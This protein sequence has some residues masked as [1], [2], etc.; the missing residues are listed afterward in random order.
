MRITQRAVAQTSLLGL[1]QNLER[2][3]K[4]QQQLTSGRQL[5]APSDSPTGTNKAMQVRQ[6]TAAVEQQARNISDG[7]GWLDAADTALTTILAQVRKVRDLTV[8]GLNTGSMQGNSALAISTEVTSLRE[9]L[10]GLAN[11]TIDGRPVFGGA[12][13]GSQAYD[14][15]GAFVGVGGLATIGGVVTDMTVPQLRRV[16]DTEVIR[17]DLTGPEVFGDQAAGRDLFALVGDIAGHV[18]SAG[19]DPTDLKTDLADLD[20][21]VSRLLSA[22]ADI[23]ARSA[24]MR[25][26]QEVNT[27]LQLTLKGQLADVEDVDLPKTIMEINMQRTGYEAALGATAKAIQPT[28]LDFLR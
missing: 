2:M 23:G 22:S 4:L 11:Q 24:R 7:K 14:A 5:N 16:S 20:K 21:A 1:N 18:L 15:S 17:V 25:S 6:N 10:L 9:S 13:G 8:Q 12:T 26:A 19:T 3:G 27:D 28:L